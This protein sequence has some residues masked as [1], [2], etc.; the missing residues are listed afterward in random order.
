MRIGVGDARKRTHMKMPRALILVQNSFHRKTMVDLL[1]WNEIRVVASDKTEWVER[2]VSGAYRADVV[3]LDE[4]LEGGDLPGVMAHLQSIP[5]PRRPKI[6][7]LGDQPERAP[8]AVDAQL[9]RPLDLGVFT[10][11]VVRLA[12]ES[13][14]STGV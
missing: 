12:R 8:A 6:V 9:D 1:Y 2:V 13:T 7:Y 3:V 4:E 10:R 5:E 14:L 11:E